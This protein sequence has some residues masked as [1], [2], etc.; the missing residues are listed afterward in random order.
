MG[1]FITSHLIVDGI[2]GQKMIFLKS[3]HGITFINLRPYLEHY[4]QKEQY[5]HS[6]GIRRTLTIYKII[7][8]VSNILKVFR[9]CFLIAVK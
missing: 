7:K 1:D 4:S 6:S 3:R 5:A 9:S 8:Q 2:T